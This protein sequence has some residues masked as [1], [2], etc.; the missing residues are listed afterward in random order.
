M[1]NINQ[2]PVEFLAPIRSIFSKTPKQVLFEELV[3]DILESS[4]DF[5]NDPDKLIAVAKALL[6]EQPEAGSYS[7][8]P[9]HPV[10]SIS[11]IFFMPSR[12]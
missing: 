6:R 2:L 8:S 5:K 10:S 7:S 3:E 4:K 9:E 11:C 1:A 12:I